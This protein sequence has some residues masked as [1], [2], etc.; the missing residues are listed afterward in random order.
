MRPLVPQ[1]AM[2]RAAGALQATC[3]R[4][5]P[6]QEKRAKAKT[7][8]ATK[9]PSAEEESQVFL[10]RIQDQLSYLIQATLSIEKGLATLT[11]NQESLEWII[12]T[13]V[14]DLGLKVTEIQTGVEQLQKEA[15]EKKGKETTDVFQRVPRGHRSAAVPVL[16]T[17]AVT[18]AP[19]ATASVPP[20][21]ATPPAPATSTKAF[22]LGVISTPPHGDQA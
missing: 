5:L 12:E 9:M 13:K 19:A 7:E 11:Q 1:A 8:K 16:D 4:K 18:S 21:A 10:K 22:I 3:Q 14:Y 20:P 15:E 17:R 6:A 2:M